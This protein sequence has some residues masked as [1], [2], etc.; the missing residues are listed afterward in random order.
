MS[1]EKRE[2][3]ISDLMREAGK[4]LGVDALRILPYLRRAWQAAQSPVPA[5]PPECGVCG[6]KAGENG[7]GADAMGNVHHVPSG[8]SNDGAGLP[9]QTE[10]GEP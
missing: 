1:E 3:F 2:H 7:H 6:A 8:D 4:D 9:N 10:A 5:T